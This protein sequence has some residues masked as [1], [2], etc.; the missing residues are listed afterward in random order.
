VLHSVVVR[1]VD[2]D[3]VTRHLLVVLPWKARR[4]WPLM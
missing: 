4:Y 2:V 1:A 3:S